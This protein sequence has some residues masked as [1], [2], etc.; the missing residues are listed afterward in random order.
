[1]S[2]ELTVET[3]TSAVG[4]VLHVR[5]ELDLTTGPVLRS[6]VREAPLC[7]DQW[8]IVELAGLEFCDSAGMSALI[9]A[10]N[11]ATAALAG[12]A[13]AGVPR[14]LLTALRVVGLDQVFAMYSTVEVTI[15]AHGAAAAL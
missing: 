10:R 6:A 3:G 12:F 5:G 11:C 7:A 1:V 13:L 15:E 8:L 2:D 14:H 9:A 4:P